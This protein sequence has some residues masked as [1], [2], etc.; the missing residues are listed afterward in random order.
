[1]WCGSSRKQRAC[2]FLFFL[3]PT[4][5][6]SF[7]FLPFPFLF[8]SP[9]ITP[10]PAEQ[11]FSS[12]YSP[13]TL[14]R[15]THTPSKLHLCS[16]S[17]RSNNKRALTFSS[18]RL[19]LTSAFLL[20]SASLANAARFTLDPKTSSGSH[21]EVIPGSYIVE[22][23]AGGGLGR[24]DGVV[25]SRFLSLPSLPPFPCSPSPSPPL[26]GAFLA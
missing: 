9:L 17:L 20:A 18:M 19:T 2:L 8:R 25:S 26:P 12:A 6:L 7:L 11:T 21:S 10:P 3:H 16:S 1:M 4:T 14:L 13:L 5:T 22:L 24:R 15:T 23:K